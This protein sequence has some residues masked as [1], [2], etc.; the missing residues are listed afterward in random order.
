[1]TAFQRLRAPLA[2]DRRLLSGAREVAQLLVLERYVYLMEALKHVVRRSLVL[3]AMQAI[4]Y[5]T[6]A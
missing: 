3:H 5:S 1:M 2:D 6:L 4:A